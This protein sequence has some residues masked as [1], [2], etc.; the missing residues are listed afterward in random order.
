MEKGRLGVLDFLS[1]HSTERVQG[2]V[3]R[4]SGY[5]CCNCKWMQRVVSLIFMVRETRSETSS[6][7]EKARANTIADGDGRAFSN[8]RLTWND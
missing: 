4:D 3:H 1:P 7:V 5:G 6:G 8:F 2:K